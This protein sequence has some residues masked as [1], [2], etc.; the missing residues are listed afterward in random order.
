MT[1]EGLCALQDFDL[2]SSSLEFE[3]K[4]ILKINDFEDDGELVRSLKDAREI[5]EFLKL[6]Q[7]NLWNFF[8]KNP[9]LISIFNYEYQPIQHFFSKETIAE[10]CFLEDF[11]FPEKELFIIRKSENVPQVSELF[12]GYLQTFNDWMQVNL[13][14]HKKSQEEINGE[15]A[16]ETILSLK[17]TSCQC[18]KCLADYKTKVRDQIYSD[19]VKMIE[20]TEAKMRAAI[21]NGGDKANLSSIA[22]IFTTFKKDLDKILFASRFK[23]KRGTL[24]KLEAQ[25]KKITKDKFTYPSPLAFEIEP[26]LKNYFKKFLIQDGLKSDLVSDDEYQ[27]FF[28]LLSTNIW[29]NESYLEREFK[30]QVKALMLLKRKDISASILKKYIG[31]FWAHSS[32]RQI[33]RKIIYHMGPT[34]SGKTYHAIN[35]LCKVKKGC[36]L[37]P[38]RLLA[39]ELYDTMNAKGVKTTLLTGEEVIDVPG[40]THYSSTI[41][42]ARFSEIFDCVV[43]D[44]IQMINDSQ[45]GWAWTRAL[46]NIFTETLHICGDDSALSLVKIIVDLCGDTLE[47]KHYERMTELKVEAK[48]ILIGDLDKGDALIVFSRKNALKYK[49][50][51]EQQDFKVSIVYGMLNPEVRREQ[52][53]KFDQ[54]ETD[55]IVSTDAIAMGMN[56]PIRRIVFSALSKFIDSTEFPLT[57]SEIKQIAGRSGRYLRYP[58]GYVT[59]LQRVENGIEEIITALGC[60]LEQKNECMIGP[61]L[62][63]FVQVN[64]TLSNNNL[65]E[66]KLSE[67]L[68][69]FNTMEFR[70]PFQCVDLKEMIELAEMIEEADEQSK[71]TSQEIFGFACAPVSLGLIEHVQYYVWILNQ[72]VNGKNVENEM[73]DF[74]SNNI[75]YLETTIKCVELYQWLARHFNNRGFAFDESSLQHNKSKAVNKLNELLSEKSV[76]TCS[77]CGKKLDDKIKFSICDECFNARRSRYRNNSKNDYGATTRNDSEGGSYT[78][79]KNYGR[80]P[81]RG[82]GKAP[83]KNNG[84]TGPGNKKHMSSSQKFKKHR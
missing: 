73:I 20:I 46:V 55:I 33:K 13:Q 17:K 79:K 2:L 38:L 57:K 14:Q 43:I 26:L 7:T 35:D 40:A 10:I 67:F 32:A 83:K 63:I 12:E 77:S 15:R 51:L 61:D 45:R 31:E 41:E 70:K 50:L 60:T 74:E 84:K 48:P 23:L 9:S 68:R 76:R 80:R 11:L 58:V 75:D 6:L 53:R 8:E 64:K 34:N 82:N 30:K 29:K 19:C 81:Q 47:I 24:S 78:K 39:S 42:M 52:A 22:N 28:K 37:A 36:Y 71:L 65:P 16:S 1:P 3:R 18:N 56:L 4:A 5:F 27:K 62:E 54:G 21:G 25:I 44:E 72:Y 59:C 66:L 49:S 69:L